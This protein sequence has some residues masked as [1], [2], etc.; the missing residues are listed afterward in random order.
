MLQVSNLS[1]RYG[2]DVILAGVS[3]V[4]NLGD[5]IGLIGPNGCGK[6][7]LFRCILGDERPDDGSI[8]LSP[9]GLRLGYLAQ[10]LE[11]APSETIG[12]VLLAWDRRRQVEAEVARLA[13]A[14]AN[15]TN[16]GPVGPAISDEA[17]AALFEAY[18]T[19]L[20]EL[21]ALGGGRDTYQAEAVLNGLGLEGL[22]LDKPVEILSGG[23][24]N[25][26]G[27]GARV[28]VGATVAAAG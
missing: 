6:T 14:I 11:Y 12:A 5:R 25:A 2:D 13:E 19:A 7:T 24:K 21:E 10:G 1:K 20:A 17:Q 4:V 15:S 18:N 8:I 22:P 27:V 23:Q 26:T 3:F 16:G 9:P 28:A